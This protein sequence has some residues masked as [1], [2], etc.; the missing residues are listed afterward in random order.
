VAAGITL[1]LP[2]GALL[3]L[4]DDHPALARSPA[5]DVGRAVAGLLEA[6]D[7]QA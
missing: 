6:G 4:P 1:H 2:H 7:A 3:V 5:A